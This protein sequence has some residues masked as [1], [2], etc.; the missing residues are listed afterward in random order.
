MN[1]STAL[2]GAIAFLVGAL[3][4]LSLSGVQVLPFSLAVVSTL[5]TAP[6]AIVLYGVITLVGIGLTIAGLVGADETPRRPL[7][8]SSSSLR[9]WYL[10]PSRRRLERRESIQHCRTWS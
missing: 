4:L 5:V 2:A 3:G 8:P 1:A 6:G 7:N 9:L 10:N